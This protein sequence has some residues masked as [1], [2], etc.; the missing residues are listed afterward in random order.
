MVRLDSKIKKQ[1]NDWGKIKRPFFFMFDYELEKPFVC[2]LDELPDH[3]YFEIGDYKKDIVKQNLPELQFAFTPVDNETFTKAYFNIVKEINAG[4]SYL[5]NLSFKHKLQSNWNLKQ[6]YYGSEAKHKLLVDEHF[7]VFS[8]EPFVQIKEGNILTF[9][10]KGTIDGNLPF[11]QEHLLDNI[12]EQAEHATIVDLMRNDLS[13]IATDVKVV[14]YRYLEKIESGQGSIY[15]TSSKLKGKLAYN[16]RENIGG[17]LAH[18][19]PAGSISGAPKK[20]TVQIIED[21]ENESRGYYTGV[22]GYFDGDDLYSSVMI[23]FIEKM[24]D[25]LFYRSGGG[26]TS[27]SDSEAEYQEL[28]Q[29]IYVPVSRKYKSCARQTSKSKLSSNPG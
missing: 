24:D 2:P 27:Q 18:L 13:T 12:K 11:A 29:K 20:R 16:Y 23:R 6:F 19:L 28:I 3:I 5:A 10:M 21:S 7:V 14:K 17:I 1:L 4:N 9:P 15:Q 22:F 26:I 8:P 25:E